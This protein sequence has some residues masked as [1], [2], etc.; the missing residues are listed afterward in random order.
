M[1]F[2]SYLFTGQT[3]PDPAATVTKVEE[4]SVGMSDGGDGEDEGEDEGDEGDEGGDEEEEGAGFDATGAMGILDG[5]ITE[6]K[7]RFPPL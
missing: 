4:E 6:Q 7:V 5:L 1:F 3:A 2:T